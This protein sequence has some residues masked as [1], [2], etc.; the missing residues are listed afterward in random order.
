MPQ[1]IAVRSLNKQRTWT[2]TCGWPCL[3]QC[4]MQGSVRRGTGGKA[5]LAAAEVGVRLC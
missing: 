5:V 2:V 3:H 1:K 4:A